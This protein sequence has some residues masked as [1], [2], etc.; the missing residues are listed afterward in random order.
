MS[1]SRLPSSPLLSLPLPFY[2]FPYAKISCSLPLSLYLTIVSDVIIISNGHWQVIKKYRE[3]FGCPFPMF[4]DGGRRIYNVSL[5]DDIFASLHLPSEHPSS[6]LSRLDVS[7]L[8]KPP[9]VPF[10]H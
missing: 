5:L 1:V 2:L 9:L 6:S 10:E 7:S 8:L 4:V 3:L